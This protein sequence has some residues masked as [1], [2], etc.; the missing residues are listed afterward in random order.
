MEELSNLRA[1][2]ISRT[3]ALRHIQSRTLSKLSSLE[4]LD[5]SWGANWGQTQLRPTQFELVCLESLTAL[6]IHLDISR[7]ASGSF[8][9]IERLKRFN[10]LIGYPSNTNYYFYGSEYT[11][12][13]VTVF[14][15][16]LSG[17]YFG[18]LLNNASTLTFDNCQELEKF[19]ESLGRNVCYNT[20]RSLTIGNYNGQ[21]PSSN[22]GFCRIPNLEL[23]KLRRVH[24][25]E[26]ISQLTYTLGLEFSKLR[27]IE[28]AFCEKLKYLFSVGGS[29]SAF[30]HLASITLVQCEELEELFAYGSSSANPFP[31]PIVLNLRRVDLHDL[32][33]LEHLSSENEPWNCLEELKV[34]G[35]E[36][37]RKLPLTAESAK[38]IK[39]II[40]ERRW[41]RRLKWNDQDTKSS[42]LQRRLAGIL[43]RILFGQSKGH[44]HGVLSYECCL[45]NDNGSPA[46]VLHLVKFNLL[47]ST[48]LTLD[49]IPFEEGFNTIKNEYDH[50]KEGLDRKIG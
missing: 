49:L 37:V 43:F 33:K 18:W 35:C 5:M 16:S 36:K 8:E 22:A 17:K 7:L 50:N 4:F 24:H 46:I 26:S 29:T 48:S 38:T 45:S 21:F 40:G 15:L 34:L 41:W 20:L 39:Q 1:L 44:R 25:L 6:Y 31:H 42:L 3:S 10:F 30:E 19:P 23:L 32:A 11:E 28:V 9:W 13:R 27:T 12:K 2:D 14:T 47:W